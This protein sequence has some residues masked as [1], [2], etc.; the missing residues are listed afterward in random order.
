VTTAVTK[1]D[2]K[3]VT[4]TDEQLLALT[5]EERGTLARRLARISGTGQAAFP[6]RRWFIAGVGLA[7]ACMVAWMSAE[8]AW[9]PSRYVVGHW[10]AAWLGF[11]SILLLSMA[12]VGWAAWRRVD[13]VP[14]ASLVTAVLLVCD[15]WFDITTATGGADVATS[16]ILAATGELPL[17]AGMVYLAHRKYMR[18]V[19]VE[20]GANQ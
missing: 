4:I 8:S 1:P 16:V 18:R 11:D 10:D 19:P 17:A 20:T 2:I 5:D 6:R 7:C 9:L 3:H 13:A 15:A 14:V 12:A